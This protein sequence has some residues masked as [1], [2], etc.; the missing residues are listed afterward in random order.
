[1]RDLEDAIQ[2]LQQ[3]VK[4]T[5]EGHPVLPSRLN[6]LGS[7]YLSLFK[8][9]ENTAYIALAIQYLEQA[10]KYT[11][12]GHSDMP[13]WLSNLGKLYNQHFFYSQ[14]H[15][16]LKHAI[17]NFHLAAISETGPLAIRLS[18]AESWIQLSKSVSCS[19]SDLISAYDLAIHLLTLL[20][21]FD[22]MIHHRY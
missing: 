3:S 19:Q 6:N 7:S 17:Y 21:S 4:L 20:T 12:E 10:V 14:D 16:S 11:P 13:R 15:N 8:R 1:M 5:P 18:A 22:T 2:N 9:T